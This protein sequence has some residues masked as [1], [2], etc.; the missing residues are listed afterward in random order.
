MGDVLFGKPKK[1]AEF[2]FSSP[3]NTSD[4]FLKKRWK[5]INGK[6][7]LIKGGSNPFQQQPFNEIIATGV[8]E[9]LSINNTIKAMVVYG[10]EETGNIYGYR[11]QLPQEENEA[12][13]ISG[14]HGRDQSLGRVGWCYR[15]LLSQGKTWPSAHG[16]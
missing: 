16:H 9:R 3:D 14:N 15:T 8:M 4:G 6:R 2:D 5:I 13:G 12:G 11:I 7:C 10:D 1:D